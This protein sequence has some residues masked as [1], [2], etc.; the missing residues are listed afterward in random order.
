MF[1]HENLTPYLP[2]WLNVGLRQRKNNSVTV[3][4]YSQCLRAMHVRMSARQADRNPNL[5]LDNQLVLQPLTA[6]NNGFHAFSTAD[7]AVLSQ[8]RVFRTFTGFDNVVEYR[9]RTMTSLA[10][11]KPLLC[12]SEVIS[13]D[14][15]AVCWS[16][17]P[18]PIFEPTRGILAKIPGMGQPTVDIVCRHLLY[19]T[20]IFQDLP[21]LHLSQFLSDLIR[22][23]DYLQERCDQCKDNDILQTRRVW[24]NLTSTDSDTILMV[25]VISSWHSVKELVLSSSCDAGPIKAVRSGLMKYER[26]LRAVGCNAISYPT[27]ARPSLS[28]SHSLSSQLQRMWKAEEQVDIT[29]CTEGRSIKAHR[30]V[31]GAMSK[32]FAAQFGGKWRTEHAI[33]Y[34][35][36]EDPDGF[37]SYQTLITMLQYAYQEPIDWTDMQVSDKDTADDEAG[38][39]NLLLDLLQGASFW[40]VDSLKSEVEDRILAAGRAFINLE[41]VIVVR[42]RAEEADAKALAQMCSL[43]IER[44][45]DAVE[46]A[47]AGRLQ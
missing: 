6:S 14:H 40:L 12:L 42:D 15:A 26:L 35:Q 23:Y 46:K 25:D 11:A 20:E 4:D 3:E 45:K 39:L 24:L 1:L 10:T 47:H 32:K 33:N 7:L 18:F 28:Q 30:V 27:V 13:Y 43:F 37:L 36:N 2:F 31:L 34:D 19:M 8:E 9:K 29:F 44:N 21:S 5:D 22:V 17:T 16:Q 38:K 41:N